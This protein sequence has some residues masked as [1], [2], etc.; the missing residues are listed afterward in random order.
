[1]A[2]HTAS[3]AS[4]D[5]ARAPAPVAPRRG[6]W[7][8]PLFVLGLGAALFVGL[9]RPTLGNP[10]G[11]RL[12]RE[13]HAVR[14]LL[15]E[16]DFDDAARRAALA[17]DRAEQTAPDRAAEAHFLL[18]LSLLRLAERAG[19]EHAAHHWRDARANLQ[20]AERLGVADADRPSL[21]FR[22]IQAEA[23]TGADPARVAERLA[24][25]EP[26]EADR[27]DYYA[28]LSQAYLDQSP[29]DL[30]AAL[31]AV[32]KLRQSDAN[33]EVLA[34]ARL[35]SGELKLKLHRPEEAR[36]DLEKLG[37][38]TPPDL[39]IHALVL[40]ARSYQD[41]KPPLWEKAA[42]A[43]EE[44]LRP[45]A[46]PLPNRAAVLYQ[47]GLCYAS[48]ALKDPGRA[49]D[50]WG[51]C[52]DLSSGEEG[53]AA[54]LGLAELALARDDPE[55]AEAAV[56]WLTRAV[57]DVA[58]PDGWKNKLVD[59]KSAR[60]RFEQAAQRLRQQARFE[61]AAALAEPYQKLAPE[62]APLLAAEVKAA[63]GRARREEA[64]KQSDA[65]RKEEA[66]QAA[67][68]LFL[69]SAT[70]YY[71]AAGSAADEAGDDALWLAA[72]CYR[73]AGELA[74]YEKVLRRFLDDSRDRARKP[75]R[76][77]EGWFLLGEALRGQPA[78]Q[79][80][81]DQAYLN[82]IASDEAPFVCR[83]RFQLA[84]A[85]MAANRQDDAESALDQ[86][87]KRLRQDPD[88]ETQEKTLLALGRLCFQRGN[89][90]TASTRLEELLGRPQADGAGQP[91][92][93]PEAVR[94]RFLL[95]ESYR[96]LAAEEAKAAEDPGSAINEATRKR[97]EDEQR[98][99]SFKAAQEYRDLRAELERPEAK[100]QLTPQ[101]ELQLPFL[102]ADGWF[103]AGKYSEAV[104][105]YEQLA[106]G[107]AGS[108]DG[109]A[110]LGGLVRC[111]AARRDPKF[112]DDE[113]MQQRIADIREALKS[114]DE[115][116]RAPWEDWLNNAAKAVQ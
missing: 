84:L 79:T 67:R 89:F 107:R 78:R 8:A 45:G 40:L 75:R 74:E 80:D 28:L 77:G 72:A 105:L 27:A 31:D 3:S 70:A 109:I 7:Q 63:W 106:K 71:R 59:L 73:D 42:R 2:R 21:Q 96:Q 91:A 10:A 4:S 37:P 44:A 97:H 69:Q 53:A 50:A 39:R 101:E 66:E 24:A 81:A 85:M 26:H 111:H 17:L 38:Q 93:N 64:A 13:L 100:G 30:N 76:K 55:S 11:R 33:D 90:R 36:K 16:G 23:H 48:P 34:Q 62:A 113:K 98:R 47:L 58:G 114:Q 19:P 112:N 61:S 14:Q 83:A 60:T 5:S 92:A 103:Y 20:E 116:V 46:G 99:L 52:A 102:E 1:M 68:A 43:W 25:V 104:P 35:R 110:A 12:D 82:C 57:R 108:L 95:A 87:L 94:A 6:L 86:N 18:G 115:A 56:K 15:G 9:A 51:K 49:A 88:P 32:T 41:Q 65:A 54:A 22:L 29:P